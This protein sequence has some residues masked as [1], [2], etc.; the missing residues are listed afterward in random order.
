M[1]SHRARIFGLL[2]GQGE[3]DVA[4]RICDAFLIGLIL[5]NAL[6]V[7]LVTDSAIEARYGVWFDAFEVISVG[8]FTAEYGLRVWS[9]PEHPFLRPMTPWRAR[10]RY[11]RSPLAVIDLLAILPFYFGALVPYDLRLLRLFRVLRV[12][13]LMRYSPTLETLLRVIRN[14]RRTVFGSLCVLAV[15]ILLS[16]AVLYHLEHDA[17]PQA[18][19]NMGKAIWWAIAT[20]TTVGYG[21]V[22]PVTVPGRVVG[23]VV[24]L[25]GVGIF[26]LWTSVF[27]SGFIEEMRKRSFVVTWKLVAQ[28]PVFAR[29]DAQRI[30][31]I[32]AILIPEV[33]PPRHTVIRRG[34][35][36]NCMYF[37]VAGEVEV[38][39]P[40]TVVRL[41]RGQFFGGL[42]LL[43]RRERMA[44]VTTLT[45]CQLLRLD[46]DEFERLM[47]SEPALRDEIQLLAEERAAS[48]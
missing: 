23:S 22:I 13:K 46:N 27:A 7:V 19:S 44:T 11:M 29:L 26:A 10:M 12:L 35:A 15:I 25:L 21:D 48:P 43:Q 34:E 20:L 8:A 9:A 2:E 45:E 37:I 47:N 38:D 14:E 3:R 40:H 32:A 41:G 18:F 5:A 33:A 24:M 36:G 28:V 30:A 17:Q 31:E 4:G 6:A 39:L 1:T 42:E 16:A